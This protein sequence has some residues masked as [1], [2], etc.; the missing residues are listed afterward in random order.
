L[1]EFGV[2][3]PRWC[4][5]FLEQLDEAKTTGPDH[6]RAAILKKICKQIAVP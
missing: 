3:R 4:L 5:R 6:I 1:H 2:L